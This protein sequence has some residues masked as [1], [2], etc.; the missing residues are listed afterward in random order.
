MYTVIKW[1]TSYT[2]IRSYILLNLFILVTLASE[3][4][5]EMLNDPTTL[6][7]QYIPKSYLNLQ[8]KIDDKILEMK[9]D[10]LAP[11]MSKEEF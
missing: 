3:T 9:E 5:N 10:K 6:L 4:D 1:L 2:S 11:M 7:Q 8:N